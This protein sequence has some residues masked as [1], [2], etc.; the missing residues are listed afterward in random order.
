[1]PIPGIQQPDLITI[2]PSLRLRSYDLVHDFAL[3]WYQDHETLML[4][5]GKDVPY[6]PERLARMYQYLNDHGELYYIE[7]LRDSVWVPIGDV[8]FWQ[9][10]MPIV[11]GDHSLR[12]K[13]IGRQTVAALIQRA[14]E[15]KYPVIYVDTIYDYNTGSRK[16]F[17]ACG[18]EAFETTD[19]GHRYRLVLGQ[20]SCFVK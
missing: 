3:P 10:D 16:M 13:G 19:K 7:I 1:M 9:Y 11:I 6:T 12:G 8:T 2:S 4:V 20:A 17:E 15:L 5:D 18:F 14:R